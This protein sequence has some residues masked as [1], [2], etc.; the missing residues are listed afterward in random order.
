MILQT[1]LTVILYY[2]TLTCSREKCQAAERKHILLKKITQT[3]TTTNHASFQIFCF[4]FYFLVIGFRSK[5][6]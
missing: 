2:S 3:T 5:S 6:M 4:Y 1:D